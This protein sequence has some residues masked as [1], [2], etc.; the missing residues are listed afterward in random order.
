MKYYIILFLFIAACD[1][2]PKPQPE[3]ICSGESVE[4]DAGEKLMR[5]NSYK[6]SCEDPNP[7]RG[8]IDCLLVQEGEFICSEEWAYFPDEIE[9]FQHEEGFIY[10]L[11]VKVVPAEEP[12]PPDVNPWRYI[13][14]EV[15]SK[16]AKP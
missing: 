3:I 16:V 2:A 7:N 14:V 1:K 5:I 4:L 15:L 8:E 11:K 13:L 10:L 9:G 6:E 12:L